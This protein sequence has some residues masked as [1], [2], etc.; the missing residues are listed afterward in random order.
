MEL[1]EWLRGVLDVLKFGMWHKM[2]LDNLDFT[3]ATIAFKIVEQ[4]KDKSNM[5]SLINKSLGILSAN[6]IYALWLFLKSESGGDNI[7]IVEIIERFDGELDGGNDEE[8]VINLS[9]NLQKL[10]FSK[11]LLEK[12]FIYARYRAKAISERGD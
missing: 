3:A 4:N 9:N 12:T 1:E 5:E 10:L 7:R 8:K 2:V 6:G 11:E